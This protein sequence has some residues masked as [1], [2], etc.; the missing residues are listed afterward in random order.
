[1]F[2]LWRKN[3]AFVTVFAIAGLVLRA[4]IFVHF[5]TIDGDSLVYGDIARNWLTHG[6][7]GLASDTVVV[8][9]YIRL[10]GYPAFLAAVWA[11]VGLEHY[12][13]ILILQILADLGTCWIVADMARRMLS[14][15]AAK[16]AFALTAVCPFLA[17][18]TAA[19]LTET[20]AIL[21]AALTLDSALAGL[22]ALESTGAQHRL[23]PWFLCGIAIASSILLRPDGGILLIAVGLFLIWKLIEGRTTNS[24]STRHFRRNLVVAGLVV[25]FTSLAPLAPWTLRN[26]RTFHRFQPLAPRYANAPDEPVYYG[27]QRWVKTWM[28]DYVSVAEI[29]W[30]APDQP[31]D[32]SLLPSRAFDSPS[33]RQR[34]AEV[35]DTGGDEGLWTAE[36]DA[37]LGQIASERI[38]RA[39]LR[40]Y[41]FLPAAR[42]LDMWLRPRTER[43]G[44]SDRWWRLDNPGQCAW[45]ILLGIVNLLYVGT[46]LIGML[47]HR[48]IRFAALLII[49]LVLRS[50]FL[51]TLENPEPR[52][53]LECYPIVL[54]F[55]AAALTSAQAAQG[56]KE[57][58]E[59]SSAN[60]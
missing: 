34:T 8:P 31:F 10:P 23:G 59:A 19:P 16:L 50:L 18:Y 32:L 46:A 7:F 22:G 38:R 5:Q 30:V 21:F 35:F 4:W 51:G 2:S 13:A 52:Y 15:R 36:R 11:V 43:F 26:W 12:N 17:T 1:M 28:V 60:A 20:L 45:A 27:F 29:Y 54:V 14:D 49:F 56:R 9:T 39:P 3:K 58:V 57:P 47:R 25:A 37:V 41:V 48:N 40:Y 24:I 42:I 44:I 6:I 33:E 53:T 55:A